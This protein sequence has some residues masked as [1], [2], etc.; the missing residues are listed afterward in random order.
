MSDSKTCR[1][2]F[3]CQQIKN[4]LSSLHRT[5]SKAVF[6][7]TLFMT[8]IMCC[9]ATHDTTS[10]TLLNSTNEA[11]TFLTVYNMIK[12]SRLS[13]IVSSNLKEQ[14]IKEI[15]KQISPIGIPN[16]SG[17]KRVKCGDQTKTCYGWFRDFKKKPICGVFC[18]SNPWD[19]KTNIE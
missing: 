6:A 7:T 16:M 1:N 9:C 18:Q 5:L 10:S 19:I 11:N 8:K 2:I 15:D 13:N 14:G 4:C 12:F 17:V 3:P